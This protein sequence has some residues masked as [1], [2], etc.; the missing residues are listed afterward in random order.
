MGDFL[1]AYID[2]YI[3]VSV[4]IGIFITA[5]VIIGLI[6]GIMIPWLHKRVRDDNDWG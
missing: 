1:M 3:F 5:A 2:I 6:A 4:M